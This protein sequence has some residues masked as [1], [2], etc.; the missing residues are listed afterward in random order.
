MYE[1]LLLLVLL[2]AMIFS[3]YLRYQY[4]TKVDNMKK[5]FKKTIHGLFINLDKKE[6]SISF[7]KYIKII[8]LFI[9][10]NKELLPI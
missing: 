5:T 7:R 2:A 8:L 6:G 3:V 9:A 4:H 10:I 1:Y